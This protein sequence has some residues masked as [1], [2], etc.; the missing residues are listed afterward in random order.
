MAEPRHSGMSEAA[1]TLEEL[2]TILADLGV[3]LDDGHLAAAVDLLLDETGRLQHDRTCA[4]QAIE[5]VGLAITEFVKRNGDAVEAD[6]ALQAVLALAARIDRHIAA[7]DAT[8]L[9]LY[10]RAL[11]AS[12]T[13]VV[14][15]GRAVRH[16]ALLERFRSTDDIDGDV[17]ECGVAKGLSFL[18]LCFDHA[19]RHAGWRGAG[20]VVIDSFA[21]LSEPGAED[22]DFRGMGDAER[23]RVAAMTRAGR[24]AFDYEVVSRRIWHEFPEVEIHRGWI[25]AVLAAVPERR[26]R[27]VHVDVDL[28][29]P[30]R[31]A[32]AYFVPRM[33][34]GGVIVTDDYNWP[35]GRRAVDETCERFGLRLHTTDTSLA[36]VVAG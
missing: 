19:S 27:F 20:F 24:F 29:E 22:L 6:R 11:I 35:G 3:Y 14:P 8:R 15:L 34:P 30:T 16:A 36:Y 21:G 1:A 13:A 33:L 17:A 2:R 4:L 18:H 25:P 31:E 10:R 23:E 9:G 28:Y 7:I 32:F 26:Y 12:Q 5:L